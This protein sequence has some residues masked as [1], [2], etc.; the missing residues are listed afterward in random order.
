MQG[1]YRMQRSIKFRSWDGC[2]L[3]CVEEMSELHDPELI[4]EQ[5]TGLKDKNGKEI[6]EGDIVVVPNKYI[7]FDGNKPVYRGTVEWVYSQW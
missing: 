3:F 2:K 5:F 7:W 4:V 6:F 1:G